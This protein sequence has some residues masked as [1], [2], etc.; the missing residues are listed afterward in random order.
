MTP[1]PNFAPVILILPVP[2]LI[3]S[4]VNCCCLFVSYYYLK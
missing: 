4:V 1:L 3:I 2:L